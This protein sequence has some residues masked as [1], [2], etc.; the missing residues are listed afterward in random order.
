[1]TRRNYSNRWNRKNFLDWSESMDIKDLINIKL[2]VGKETAQFIPL[3]QISD[4]SIPTIR[5]VHR[6]NSVDYL[7]LKKGIE[8]DGQRQPIVLRKLTDDEKKISKNAVAVYG[9]IDGHHRFAIAKD[10]KQK[11]ILAVIDIAEP[12]NAHD[13]ILAMRFNLSSIKMKPVEKGKVISDLLETLGGESN[14][15]LVEKIGEEFFG[16]KKSMTYYCWR[17][18]KKSIDEHTVEKPREN[19]FDVG[20]IRNLAQGLPEDLKNISAD[21]GL[22]QLENIKMIEQQLK[23]LKKGIKNIEAVAEAI[24]AQQQEKLKAAREK[25]K[26]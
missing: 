19:N 3:E 17:L 9:I 5:P 11:E 12:S 13:T 23:Y 24:K 4:K 10:L 22:K 26:S 7:Q 2:E 8:Q 14:Q 16:L 25:K 20:Q 21:D 6:K 15:E 1:M 18:Y